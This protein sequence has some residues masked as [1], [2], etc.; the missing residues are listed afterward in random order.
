[1]QHAGKSNIF[2]E[3]D[4]LRKRPSMLFRG[5]ATYVAVETYLIGYIRA[6]GDYSGVNLLHE[7]HLWFQEKIQQ[8]ASCFFMAHVDIYYHDKS[9]KERIAVLIDLVEEFFRAHPT[10]V[11]NDRL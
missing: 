9:E 6:M 4:Y 5:G 11:A 8:K 3:I 10:F 1:M 2:K 7:M